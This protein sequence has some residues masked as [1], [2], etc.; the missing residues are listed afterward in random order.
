M[1]E[2]VTQFID[3]L[4]NAKIE[5][6]KNVFF[7]NDEENLDSK[8]LPAINVIINEQTMNR[9][10]GTVYDAILDCECRVIVSQSSDIK[11][12]LKCIVVTDNLINVLK[13]YLPRESLL[14][15]DISVERYNDRIIR[16]VPFQLRERIHICQ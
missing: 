8:S 10:G 9:E 2:Q 3:H 16:S 7:E 4:K 15:Q 13:D 14:I 1:I 6:V 12:A 11:E 5:N